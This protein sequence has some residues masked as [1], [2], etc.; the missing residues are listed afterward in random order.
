M[1]VQYTMHL[2]LLHVLLKNTIFRVFSLAVT[3]N[4]SQHMRIRSAILKYMLPIEHLLIGRN[5]EEHAN[6]LY[7]LNYSSVQDYINATGMA[8]NGNLS[9]EFEIM[10]FSTGIILI[11]LVLM[12][13]ATHGVYSLQ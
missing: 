13:E 3:G 8:K 4:E 2:L 10:V 9:T 7:T 6:Y 1:A 12:Q 11:S 5:T